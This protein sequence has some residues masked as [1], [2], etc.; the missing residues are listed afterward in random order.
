MIFRVQRETEKNFELYKDA[1]SSLARGPGRPCIKMEGKKMEN[2]L[3]DLFSELSRE[4]KIR[5]LAAMLAEEHFRE[6]TKMIF[7]PEERRAG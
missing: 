2:E 4:A 1:R 7:A 5:I 3:R 6:E